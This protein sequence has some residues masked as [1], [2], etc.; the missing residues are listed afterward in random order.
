VT[1]LG[2][3]EDVMT[4]VRKRWYML[5]VLMLLACPP[6]AHAGPF[7]FTL[8]PGSGDISGEPGSTIGWGYSIT[9]VSADWL[10]L[11]S[12][13]H[14]PFASATPDTSLFDFPILAPGATML[15]GLFQITWDALA[16]IGLVERGSVILSAEFWDGDP[17]DL[18]APGSFL[19][20]ADDQSAAFTATVTGPTPVPE[21]G[22]LLLMGS[23]AVALLRR[24]RK[25]RQANA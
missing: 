8:L 1:T 12:I 23:G 17:L 11:S 2:F 14:D 20:L 4:A 9:N 13:N 16:P 18:S 21:P 24:H 3:E 6:A 19:S 7:T 10:V 5:A 15:G 22:T 25:R